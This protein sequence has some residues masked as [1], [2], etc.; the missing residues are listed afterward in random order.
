MIVAVA[1]V[2]TTDGGCLNESFPMTAVVLAPRWEDRLNVD[3]FALLA[4]V[5]VVAAV[6]TVVNDVL[7][8]ELATVELVVVLTEF[9]VRP[10]EEGPGRVPVVADGITAESLESERCGGLTAVP[11]ARWLGLFVLLW[12]VMVLR[13]VGGGSQLA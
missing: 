12:L 11:D 3:E 2:V 7:V 1:V 10:L 9:A 4:P 8:A 6:V 13:L 5:C